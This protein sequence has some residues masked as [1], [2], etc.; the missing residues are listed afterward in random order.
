MGYAIFTSPGKILWH[1]EKIVSI[2]GCNF[3][4]L[5]RIIG[6]LESERWSLFDNLVEPNH[7]RINNSSIYS[8]VFYNP[9]QQIQSKSGVGQNQSHQFFMFNKSQNMSKSAKD[10]PNFFSE[11][12][13]IKISDLLTNAFQRGQQENS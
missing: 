2:L 13:T 10:F 9:N 11:K 12:E 8:S 6:Q 1:N 4:T 5:A 3:A 7:S